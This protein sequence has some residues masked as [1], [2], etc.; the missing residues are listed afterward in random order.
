[1]GEAVAVAT[2]QQRQLVVFDLGDE[3]YGVDIYQVREIIRV[4]DITR[5]PRTPD[6]VEGVIN[7]RG[8]VIPVLNLR[9]R[10]DMG[11][12]GASDDAR[13]VIVELEDQLVGMRVDGVSEVLRIEGEQVEPPS[14]YIVNVDSQFVTGI[15][16]LDEQ[17]VIL[18]DL[19]RVLMRDEREQLQAVA[20]RAAAEAGT[21]GAVE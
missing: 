4:P 3:A 18:L 1:M 11:L 12:E 15:A 20:E 19:N 8:G 2:G 9:R 16:R 10:F 17:L 6:Y 7:L 21:D 13:I 14:P 5:V